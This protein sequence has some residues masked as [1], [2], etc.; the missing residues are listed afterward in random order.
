MSGWKNLQLEQPKLTLFTISPHLKWL[1]TVPNCFLL[2]ALSRIV[3]PT[4]KKLVTIKKLTQQRSHIHKLTHISIKKKHCFECF[5]KVNEAGKEGAWV[6]ERG[7]WRG[8]YISMFGNILKLAPWLPTRLPTRLETRLAIWVIFLQPGWKKNNQVG[9][10][11]FCKFPTW[12][13]IR[14]FGTLMSV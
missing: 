6:G 7:W 4:T 5:K 3:P 1:Q 13:Q 8:V 2:F 9:N 14:F 11:V 12:L 10:L